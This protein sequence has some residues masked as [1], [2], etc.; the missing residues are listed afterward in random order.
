[1]DKDWT[2]GMMSDARIS[3]RQ[4]YY[5]LIIL[6]AIWDFRTGSDGFLSLPLRHDLMADGTIFRENVIVMNTRDLSSQ[7]RPL[8][9]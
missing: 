6:R 7:R 4:I 8:A 9:D 2:R 1:M 3:A 5:S